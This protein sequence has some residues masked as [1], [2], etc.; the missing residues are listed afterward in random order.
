MGGPV[1]RSTVLRAGM[2]LTITNI[3]TGALNYAYQ[4][5]MGRLLTP[6]EFVAMNAILA[7]GVVCASPL[8]AIVMWVTGQVA[9]AMA[10]NDTQLVRRFY[11]RSTAVLVAVWIVGLAILFAVMPYVEG[12]MRI[13]DRPSL[14]LFGV[15]TGVGACVLVNGAFLQGLQRFAWLG[16]LG[17]LAAVLRIVVS[18]WFVVQ[19][20]WGVR[21]ALGGTL[22][23]VL[24]LWL[25]GS[26]AI[27]VSIRAPAEVRSRSVHPFVAKELVPMMLFAV[28][29][30]VMTQLD[31]VLVNHYFEPSTSSAFA[32]AA[33]LGKAVLYLPNGIA[34]AMFPMIARNRSAAKPS[35]RILKQAMPAAI[36]L[37]GCMVLVFFLFGEHVIGMMYGNRYEAAGSL[38]AP[39]S[40]ALFPMAVVVLVAHFLIAQGKA[41]FSW[42]FFAC[43]V[44][45]VA[46]IHFWHPHLGA[47]VA[48]LGA[49]N[50]LLAIVG[51]GML[52]LEESLADSD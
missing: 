34:A 48:V 28:A 5:L 26:A 10:Y 21:G 19:F 15:A 8:Y 31:M 42:F 9:A 20:D 1:N 7:L 6:G 38:L 22:L 23:S 49:Y 13:T 36:A 27:A 44:M 52:W 14:W 37:C 51:C 50:T 32:P 45:E 17:V 4:I 41:L 43:A 29:F 33:I 18:V 3:V 12:Y 16:G 46:T 24:L 47:V 2:L 35:G 40:L 30:A 25:M 11:K 39:Y